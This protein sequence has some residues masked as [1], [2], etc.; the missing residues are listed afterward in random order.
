MKITRILQLVIAFF[1]PALYSA[2]FDCKQASSAVEKL[3]CSKAKL[4][5]LDSELHQEYKVWKRHFQLEPVE[6]QSFLIHSQRAWLRA[7]N[8]C[9]EENCIENAYTKRLKDL[10]MVAD[11]EDPLAKFVGTHELSVGQGSNTLSVARLSSKNLIV[12]IEGTWPSS[13]TPPAVTCSFS[14]IAT[15]FGNKENVLSVFDF[16]YAHNRKDRQS[17]SLLIEFENEKAF[18]TYYKGKDPG[19]CGIGASLEGSYVQKSYEA[20]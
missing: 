11:P 5:K 14:G 12:L 19:Y 6:A 13:I 20:K 3:I 16:V 9:I 10:R 4:S 18:V 1:A 7:R 17:Q 8:E 15:L 2:S